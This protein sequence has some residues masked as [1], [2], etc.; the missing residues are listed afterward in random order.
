MTSLYKLPTRSK[1]GAMHVVIESPRGSTVKLKFE[2]KL[3]AF[4]IARP[5]TLGVS[6]PFDWGFIPSTRAPDGDPLDAMVLLDAPTYPGVVIPCAPLGVVKISQKS[7]KKPG[8]R[9]RNDRIIAVPVDAPRVAD[10]RDARSIPER[11]RR[12]IEQFFLAAVLLTD[13]DVKLL[14]WDGPEAA[15]RLVD[16]SARASSR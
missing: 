14:G 9:E 4:T 2:P 3:G 1:D 7:K 5:L 6:Y 12:E 15:E 13:K 16:T 10:V 11:V 8:G